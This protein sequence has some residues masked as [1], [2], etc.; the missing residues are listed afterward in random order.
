[1]QI[2]LFDTLFY[3]TYG[4]WSVWIEAVHCLAPFHYMLTGSV[5]KKRCLS[6]FVAC[7]GLRRL[8]IFLVVPTEQET[9]AFLEV[10]A[11]WPQW[12]RIVI[13]S[14]LP[15]EPELVQS[16][17]CN[18]HFNKKASVADPILPGDFS[19]TQGIIRISVH[20]VIGSVPIKETFI[21]TEASLVGIASLVVNTFGLSLGATYTK[22]LWGGMYLYIWSRVSWKQI[23]GRLKFKILSSVFKAPVGSQNDTL[24]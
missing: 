22:S 16:C 10:L 7:L 12:Q 20:R 13:S 8:I 5:K 11:S 15:V 4:N 2:N 1:M 18:F 17:R 14:F 23:Y 21:L 9:G 24:L 19:I 3:S 6:W